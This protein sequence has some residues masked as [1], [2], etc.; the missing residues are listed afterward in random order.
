M[1]CQDFIDPLGIE[2]PDF[3]LLQ[4]HEPVLWY[5]KPITAAN[6][7]I[8]LVAPEEKT[9]SNEEKATSEDNLNDNSSDLSENTV[10]NKTTQRTSMQ[11]MSIFGQKVLLPTKT[12]KLLP[13]I[14][15]K[16][17]SSSFLVEERAFTYC[18]RHFSGQA[19]NSGLNRFG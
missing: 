12:K 15:K 5:S 9:H 8:K 1:C 14:K 6:V 3:D 4:G 16:R 19:E 10:P 11:L 13:L 7:F 17:S 18:L 2:I